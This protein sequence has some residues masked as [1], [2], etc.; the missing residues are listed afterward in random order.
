M[1][2]CDRCGMFSA[3]SYGQKCS[4]C[5][6][7]VVEDIAPPKKNKSVFILL[8]IFVG[9]LGIHRFYLGGFNNVILG[10]VMFL[11]VWTGIPSFIALVEA[12]VIGLNS[13]DHRF[14]R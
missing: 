1:Q 6:H 2:Q 11:L 12:V 5:R 13:N 14:E 7:P 3:Y 4:V 8:A 10:L 9:G